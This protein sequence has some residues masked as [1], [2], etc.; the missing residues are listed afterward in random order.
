M[1]NYGNVT[2]G[3]SK[4]LPPDRHSKSEPYDPWTAKFRDECCLEQWLN[5]KRRVL[6]SFSTYARFEQGSATAD[7]SSGLRR[8][9]S[10][11][12]IITSV[13]HVTGFFNASESQRCDQWFD[14]NR[15][16]GI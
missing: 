10:A 6:G 15:N 12:T 8:D 7:L 4:S 2:I 3:H 13:S 11:L 14:P 1:L 9:R 16:T 5:A